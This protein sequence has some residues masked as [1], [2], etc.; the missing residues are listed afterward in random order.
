M[1]F[2]QFWGK[3]QLVAMLLAAGMQFLP[4]LP[5]LNCAIPHQNSNHAQDLSFLLGQVHKRGKGDEWEGI[6]Q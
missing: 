1:S 4:Q 2:T 5:E 6:Y 3:I